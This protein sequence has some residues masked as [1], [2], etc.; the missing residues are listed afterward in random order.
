MRGQTD[1]RLFGYQS[2]RHQTPRSARISAAFARASA[3]WGAVP[4]S[5]SCL[6]T[7]A[8]TLVPSEAVMPPPPSGA[9]GRSGLGAA[10]T[11]VS[12]DAGGGAAGPGGS[13]PLR[14]DLGRLGPRLGDSRVGTFRQLLLIH[15]LADGGGVLARRRRR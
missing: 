13:G 8:R 11:G 10:A 15:A 1:R 2:G 7:I 5:S 3:T 12:G 9:S 14:L 4:R 6:R